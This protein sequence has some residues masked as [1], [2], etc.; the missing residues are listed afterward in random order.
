MRS[1]CSSLLAAP[2]L[3][4]LTPDL[5]RS[6]WQHYAERYG[7]KTVPKPASPLMRLSAV[8]LNALGYMSADEFARYTTVIRHRIYTIR[9]PGSDESCLWR[10]VSLAVHEHQHVVQWRR[11]GFVRFAL[12]YA[13]QHARAAYEAEAYGCDL[14]MAA[15]AGRPVPSPE[16]LARTIA[17]YSCGELA[18]ASARSELDATAEWANNGEVRNES[19]RVAVAFLTEATGYGG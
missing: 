16:S 7:T 17:G 14:E 13:N 11:E 8:S 1:A 12:K 19:S 10:D 3:L 9:E 4:P 15:W 2:D 5:V 18:V 6:L